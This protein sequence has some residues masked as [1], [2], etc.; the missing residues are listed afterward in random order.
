M[1]TWTDEAGEWER[2]LGVLGEKGTAWLRRG[3]SDCGARLGW[4]WAGGILTRSTVF[5]P[6]LRKGPSPGPALAVRRR[7]T[8]SRVKTEMQNISSCVGEMGWGG[9]SG[10]GW[11]KPK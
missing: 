7:S 1:E 9:R 4:V 2:G 10:V 3:L 11:G 6:L 8:Y 5:G